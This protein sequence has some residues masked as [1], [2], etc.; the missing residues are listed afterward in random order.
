[1]LGNQP[2]RG[3]QGRV[4]HRAAVLIDRVGPE[5]WHPLIAYAMTRTIQ[6]V[7]IK[8]YCI[9]RLVPI[10][11][12]SPSELP[13]ENARRYLTRLCQHAIKMSSHLRH[14][15]RSHAGGGAPPDIRHA[16]CSDTDGTLVLNWGQ[17]TLQAAPG[18]LT[19]RAEAA[20]QDSLALIKDLV[21]GRLEKFGRREHLTVT[22][23]P[24]EGA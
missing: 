22:W 23:R 5:L 19:L 14:R 10:S 15:P 4:A 20:D 9:D 13:T 16:E 18:M 17:C 11:R 12:L 21:A 1:V 6:F 3:V 2:G 7:L 8:T 24:A